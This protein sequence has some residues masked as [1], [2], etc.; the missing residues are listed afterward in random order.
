MQLARLLKA[1]ALLVVTAVLVPIVTATGES[2]DR[3]WL[4]AFPC[5]FLLGTWLQRW[6]VVAVGLM[7]AS[8]GWLF[9]LSYNFARLV[10]VG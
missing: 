4:A 8:T 10:W 7:V 3:Y 1:V 6:P 5:F 2:L 9:V